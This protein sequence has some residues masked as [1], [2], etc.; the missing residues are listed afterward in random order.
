MT[1]L[2][3]LFM[4][5]ADDCLT[6]T[7]LKAI[8]ASG[9]SRVPVYTPGFRHNIVGLIMVKELLQYRMSH[10]VPISAIKLRSVPR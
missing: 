4:L 6:L 1:P 9:H 7:T 3:S 8:L 5:S 2:E 10:D